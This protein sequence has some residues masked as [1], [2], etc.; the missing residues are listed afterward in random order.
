MSIET[1]EH[2]L[3]IFAP[4]TSPTEEKEGKLMPLFGDPPPPPVPLPSALDKLA[5]GLKG[6]AENA[7]SLYEQVSLLSNDD[8]AE[9][10][11]SKERFI[12]HYEAMLDM[13]DNLSLMLMPTD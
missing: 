12:G 5:L 9:M 7:E 3:S 8:A 13:L 11:M 1:F 2:M 10:G 4:P 6:L